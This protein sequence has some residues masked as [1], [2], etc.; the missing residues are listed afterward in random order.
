MMAL[1]GKILLLIFVEACA[2]AHVS[3]TRV[4][5][6]TEHGVIGDG[7][8]DDTVALQQILDSVPPHSIVLVPAGRVVITGPLTLRESDF[9][10]QIDGKLQAWDVTAAILEEIWPTLPPL[11]TYGSSEDAGHWLQYQALIYATNVT[12]LQI[13]G[14]GVIDGKGG[15][16][17]DAFQHNNSLLKAG[18]PNLIQIVNSSRI[19]IDSVE[20]RDSPFWTLHPVLSQNVYIHH[21]SIRAPLY[22]PNVDGIDPA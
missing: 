16:W 18:R 10:F 2:A 15:P 20:L 3:F 9:A 14:T 4:L 8:Q 5:D 17:W 11:P 7:L 6:V 1:L 22:A 19:E 21:I 12:N 13:T